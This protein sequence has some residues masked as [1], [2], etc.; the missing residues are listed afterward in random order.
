MVWTTTTPCPNATTSYGR[1]DAKVVSYNSQ[2]LAS[3][4]E[5]VGDGL[6]VDDLCVHASVDGYCG[7]DYETCD[8]QIP[9]NVHFE[10]AGC[11]FMADQVVQVVTALLGV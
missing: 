3:L 4:T 7:E 9:A 10:E 5:L 8:L 1:T 6:V 11:Q 2:A